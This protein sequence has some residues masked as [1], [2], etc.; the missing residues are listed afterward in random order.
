MSTIRPVV[1][2][3]AA[4]AAVA[5]LLLAGSPA[6][7]AATGALVW[8]TQTVDP[9]LPYTITGAPRVVEGKVIIGNSGA[10]YGV[11]GYVSA[12][13]AESGDLVW[14]THTVPGNPADGFESP[15]MER[16]AET[17]SGEWWKLGGGGTAWDSMAYDPQLR[18]LYVGT[19]NGSPW[20]RHIRSPGGG[21][22]L[23]LSSILAL[24]C[25]GCR[26]CCPRRPVCWRRSAWIR[27]SPRASS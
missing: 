5:A 19:G 21:D 24:R 7:D 1:A 3:T 26:A 17:W 9:N 10:E 15:A 14:R 16:A 12:Y 4:A 8:E 2:V 27:Q 18:L 13:D 22:N 6:V 11:R 20:T 25:G 23:Y